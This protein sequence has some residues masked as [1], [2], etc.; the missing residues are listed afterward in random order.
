MVRNMILRPGQSA[1][2][3][4]VSVLPLGAGR[5]AL[6]C[7]PCRD[8]ARYGDGTDDGIPA[9]DWCPLP[10]D[11]TLRCACECHADGAPCAT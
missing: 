10:K 2:P 4:A 9:D 11:T 1:P 5:D 3:L 7:A 8:A 6:R